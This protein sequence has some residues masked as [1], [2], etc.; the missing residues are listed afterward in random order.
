MKSKKV[1]LT[2]KEL[3]EIILKDKTI[4]EIVGGKRQDQ[5]PVYSDTTY[6]KPPIARI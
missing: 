6:V 4:S 1:G 3:N 5:G 2:E